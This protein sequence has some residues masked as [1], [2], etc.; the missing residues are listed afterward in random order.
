[1]EIK[2]EYRIA[3]EACPTPLMLVAQDGVIVLTNRRFDSLFGYHEQALWGQS[4]DLLVPEEI[5]DAHPELRQA[6][7]EVPTSRDMG[8]GRDLFG[9]RKDGEKIPVEIGLDPIQSDGTTL[10]MVS[11][12]DI[13][14]RKAGETRIR[15]AL[16]AASSAMVMINDHGKIELVNEQTG[17]M[18]GYEP[19][20]LLG[21]AIEVLV[22]ERYRRKH[23]VFRVSYQNTRDRRDMGVGRDLFGRRKDGTEFPVEIGLTPIDGIDGRLIMATVI[24]ISERKLIEESI[25]RKNEELERL[26]RELSEFAYSASHDLKSP[27][28]SMVGLLDLITG[29]LDSGDHE[30]AQFNLKR[31]RDLGSRLA[32]RIEDMLTLAKS[33][34]QDDGW[35]GLSVCDEVATVWQILQSGVE[36]EIRFS[37]RFDHVDPLRTVP[38]RFHIVLE[39]LLS[40][41]IKYRDPKKAEHEIRVETWDQGGRFHLAVRDNGVGIPEQYQGTVFQLF[42]RIAD[43]SEPGNGVGLA[44]VKKNVLRLGGDVT[45]ESSDEGSI[46]TVVLPRQHEDG[47]RPATDQIL[48]VAQ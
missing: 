13:R 47:V 7:F 3:V 28:S 48:E 30:E 42:K 19:K 22:P 15:R 36:T 41:A 20:E 4:V 12:L 37:T 26:N 44:L 35:A 18:F 16:D 1:M 5:R 43:S 2:E 27:L 29:D 10:V 11:V 9:V 45:V 34:R 31:A 24:D 21:Q 38:A 14:E 39:N 25:R 40:N 46:F 23:T 32:G 6:F 33:D 17:M 8:T